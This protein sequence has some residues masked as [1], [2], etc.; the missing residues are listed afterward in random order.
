M[1]D[2]PPAP[3]APPPAIA[4]QLAEAQSA[5][6]ARDVELAVYKTAGNT[7]ADAAALLDS[8]SFMARVDGLDPAAESYATDLA[9]LITEA[10]ADP[11]F[12]APAVPAAPAQSGPDVTGTAE[13]A[14]RPDQMSVDELRE[15]R[16]A[17]RKL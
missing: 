8:R 2:T 5:L 13:P 17:R 7:G 9:T 3:Q 4:D 15:A 1:T 11:R 6:R 16:T 14:K 12:T 10:G